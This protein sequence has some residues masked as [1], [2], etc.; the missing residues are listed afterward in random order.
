MN[1]RIE[2]SLLHKLNSVTYHEFFQKKV[3][4]LLFFVKGQRRASYLPIFQDQ[5]FF[6]YHRLENKYSAAARLPAALQKKAASGETKYQI[7]P[8]T[9]LATNAHMEF[10]P[11]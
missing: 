9:L 3:Q 11:A 10:H 1:F 4:L 6:T 5:N 8:V 2:T 7:K